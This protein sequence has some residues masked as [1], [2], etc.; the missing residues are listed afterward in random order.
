M[1]QQRGFAEK[2]VAAEFDWDAFGSMIHSDEGK[3]ELQTLRSTYLD[4]KQRLANL[5]KAPAPINWTTWKQELDPK[6]VDQ[7]KGAYES[8]KLPTYQGTEAEEAKAKF[9]ALISEA[10]ALVKH[11]EQRSK[12]IAAE[13]KS[14]QAGPAEGA[15]AAHALLRARRVASVRPPPQ[16]EKARIASATI[17][18]ELA[19]DPKLASE[20]D[21]EIEKARAFQFFEPSRPPSNHF[22][23][24]NA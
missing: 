18:G 17:D 14:I 12:E 2:A 10:E 1:L 6:L 11:S 15:G 24:P 9:A 16:D 4:I 19:A 7:F 13:I 5:A 3:R 20:V 21:E 8:M 22:L 23:V